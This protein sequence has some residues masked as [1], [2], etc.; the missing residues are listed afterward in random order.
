MPVTPKSVL[1]D[2]Q[3]LVFIATFSYK[4]CCLCA[5]TQRASVC[6]LQSEELVDL[7]YFLVYSTFHVRLVF[8]FIVR[9]W[10]TDGLFLLA[11]LMQ[12]MCYWHEKIAPSLYPNAHLLS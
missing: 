12:K 7:I 2:L 5:L 3:F 11:L 9:D 8:R 1:N 10:F 4:S 6:Q